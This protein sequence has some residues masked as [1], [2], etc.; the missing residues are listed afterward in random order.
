VR[1]LPRFIADRTEKLT[2]HA[3]GKSVGKTKSMVRFIWPADTPRSIRAIR[4]SGTNPFRS[5]LPRENV[6]H[7][8][9]DIFLDSRKLLKEHT[10]VE[11]I[12]EII[13]IKLER[14]MF[15]MDASRKYLRTWADDKPQA[16]KG[17][18][19]YHINLILALTDEGLMEE[20]L[21][22]YR[23]IMSSQ[24]IERIEEGAGTG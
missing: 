5:I 16:V 15:E 9:K 24:G 1:V 22:R 3:V 14:F 21:F 18:R 6:I 8:R 20:K 10:R 4:D 13:R 12:T 17:K 7:F 2:D 19:V 23:L 11:A